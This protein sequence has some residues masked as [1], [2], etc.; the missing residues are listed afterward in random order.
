MIETQFI[1]ELSVISEVIFRLNFITDRVWQQRMLL[2]R[3]FSE[4]NWMLQ[5]IVASYAFAWITLVQKYV[6]GLLP[7]THTQSFENDV[8]P[9]D[10]FFFSVWSRRAQPHA[11]CNHH[12]S[13]CMYVCVNVELGGWV[14]QHGEN[15][16]W[17]FLGHFKLFFVWWVTPPPNSTWPKNF[18]LKIG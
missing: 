8:C 12:Q 2:T 5:R 11:W 10:C 9:G 7:A 18:F 13:V 17:P 4:V 3:N 14:T 1:L 16:P 15:E 6:I